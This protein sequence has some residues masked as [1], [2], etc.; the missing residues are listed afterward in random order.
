MVTSQK[1][2]KTNSVLVVDD[3]PDA[4]KIG[5]IFQRY[6][7]SCKGTSSPI[8]ALEIVENE[9]IDLILVD[10]NMSPIDGVELTERIKKIKPSTPVVILSA[11]IHDGFWKSKVEEVEDY[12]ED[13]FEKPLPIME[14]RM[15][16]FFGRLRDII[17]RAKKRAGSPSPTTGNDDPFC[18]SFRSYLNLDDKASQQI[19]RR[20]WAMKKAW[21]LK[22][23]EEQGWVWAVLCGSEIVKTSLSG[24]PVPTEEELIAYGDKYDRIPFL[25]V[26]PPIVEESTWA[27]TGRKQLN[28]TDDYYP[29][30]SCSVEAIPGNPES[31]LGDFDTGAIVTCI[32]SEVVPI[33]VLDPLQDSKHLEEEYEFTMKRIKFMLQDEQN[34][35]ASIQ[36]PVYVIQDWRTSPFVK[37]NPQRQMLAGRDILNNLRLRVILDSVQRKTFLELC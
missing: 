31:L 13:K 14:A 36:L 21:F 15:A 28:G 9:E 23:V 26:R 11:Y 37:V 29:T 16:E 30:I 22:Q 12:F 18:V 8:E 32:S 27:S 2:A 3:D 6:G 10:L 35:R 5:K 19:R 33:G 25:F 34:Q 7:F 17:E 1:E 24:D 4:L 20:A